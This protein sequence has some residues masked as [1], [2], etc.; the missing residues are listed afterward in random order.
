MK[1][2]K[3]FAQLFE[4]ASMHEDC[5]EFF[6]IAKGTEE[7]KQ[8][9]TWYDLHPTRTGKIKVL[10]KIAGGGPNNP[11]S[12][13]FDKPH[14]LNNQWEFTFVSTG[15]YYGQKRSTD[16]IDLLR[17]FIRD[18][19]FK[20][21]PADF[22]RKESTEMTNDDAFIFSKIWESPKDP[23][24]EYRADKRSDIITDLSLIRGKSELIDRVNSICGNIYGFGTNNEYITIKLGDTGRNYS[25]PNGLNIPDALMEILGIKNVR[26]GKGR[27]VTSDGAD[28]TILPKGVGKK[29]IAN[30]LSP[31]NAWGVRSR[32]MKISLG[33]KT[34]DELVDAIEKILREYIAKINIYGLPE[35]SKDDRDLIKYDILT[36]LLKDRLLNG[37]DSTD[38]ID[39]IFDDYM[40]KNPLD[41]HL[42][43]DHPE[44]KAGVLKRT[45]MRDYSAIGR[46]LKNGL[47]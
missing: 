9:E 13:Y 20:F 42:L 35:D 33:Y 39:S 30:T 19:I 7:L 23:Y 10:S 47:I 21:A 31:K 12:P 8:I 22:N 17:T 44:I 37:T 38:N 16:L 11:G 41:L 25:D 28:I 45:G 14:Y 46:N 43:N 26:Y 27:W 18:I 24:T 32:S 6:R 36:D 2:I 1:R 15:K 34:I 40:T 5:E 4:A 29:I 3:T